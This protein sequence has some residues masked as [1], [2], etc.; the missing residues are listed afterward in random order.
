MTTFYHVLDSLR[1][2]QEECQQEGGDAADEYHH[3]EHLQGP[4]SGPLAGGEGHEGEGEGEEPQV[5]RAGRG[6]QGG[7]DG[8]RHTEANTAQQGGQQ[9]DV[10]EES[11]AEVEDDEELE[12]G[13]VSG[14]HGVL[15]CHPLP[16]TE[17]SPV[18]ARHHP[19]S[20]RCHGSP[21]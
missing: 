13:L 16:V 18:S 20:S 5:L 7:E 11:E 10:V 17:V 4:S 3:L 21:C 15:V 1:K 19:T 14:R 8:G 6:G 2:V 9:A 12:P